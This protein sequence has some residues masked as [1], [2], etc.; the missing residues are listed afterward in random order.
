MTVRRGSENVFA[1]LGLPNADKLLA[2]AKRRYGEAMKAFVYK[3]SLIKAD[4]TYVHQMDVMVAK[5]KTDA[6]REIRAKF[7]GFGGDKV[8]SV[9]MGPIDVDWLAKVIE[10]VKDGKTL[11]RA[12]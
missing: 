8:D 1:D 4:K 5:N 9:E 3:V 2:D 7:D 10:A 12:V 11:T 6:E